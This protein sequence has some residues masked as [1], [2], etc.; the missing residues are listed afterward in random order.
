MSK[1]AD[2]P[3]IRP[4]ADALREMQ[5]GRT[6]TEL[7]EQ[8]HELIARVRD[9]GKKGSLTLTITVAP[10]KNA[11][12]NTLTVSDVVTAKLPAHDRR[13]SLFYADADGNLTRR[14]PN[15][16][17]FESLR[18]VPTPATPITTDSKAKAQA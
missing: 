10:V 11:S 3:V 6:H 2:D 9:T 8:L 7:S 18:E 12:E 4:F 17:E 14:D 16:L 1:P 13:V 15:Q 5:A